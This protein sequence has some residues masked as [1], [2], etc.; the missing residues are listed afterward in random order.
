MGFFRW[1]RRRSAKKLA[2]GPFGG[3]G[4]FYYLMSYEDEYADL[5]SDLPDPKNAIAE[6]FIFRFWLTQCIYR[7]CKPDL[8]TDQEVLDQILP[9]GLSLGLKMFEH[10]NNISIENELHG[11]I[12]DIVEDRFRRYDESF[13]TGKYPDDPFAMKDLSLQLCIDLD[14]GPDVDRWTYFVEKIHA[15]VSA[16]LNI[17]SQSFVDVPIPLKSVPKLLLV[18]EFGKS[19]T[20]LD[21]STIVRNEQ[22]I[23]VDVIYVL[24]PP[25]KDQRNNKPVKRMLMKEEYDLESATFRVHQIEFEYNDGTH[26]EPFTPIPQWATATKGNAKTLHSLRTWLASETGGK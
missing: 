3:Q 23:A 5:L 19:K 21:R 1:I 15:Q 17:W 14:C 22:L 16:I 4:R 7:L 13:I 10:L 12:S 9:T 20:Y 18:N 25:G 8:L 24:D 2:A 11:S 26:G 6:L